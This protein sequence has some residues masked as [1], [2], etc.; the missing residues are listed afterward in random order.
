M[1]RG[2]VW[3]CIVSLILL[4][5]GFDVWLYAD[6]IEGNSITQVIRTELQRSPLFA[7]FLGFVFGGLFFHF[8]DTNEQGK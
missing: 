5:G 8:F 7:G 2:G 3:V 4:I 6:T 1:T